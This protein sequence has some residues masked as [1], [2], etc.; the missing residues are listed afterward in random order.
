MTLKKNK[1]RSHKNSIKT[2][3]LNANHVWIFLFPF[4][5]IVGASRFGRK[6]IRTKFKNLFHKLS[7]FKKITLPLPAFSVTSFESFLSF[8]IGPRPIHPS[9]IASRISFYRRTLRQAFSGSNRVEK[10]FQ[11]L[12]QLLFDLGISPGYPIDIEYAANRTES[13]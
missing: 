3:P 11:F 2:L 5:I 6:K 7:S 4:K 9:F 8:D 10:V 1:A 13:S 12:F